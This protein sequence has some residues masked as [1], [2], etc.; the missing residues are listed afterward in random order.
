MGQ[1][2]T[3]TPVV[4][5]RERLRQVQGHLHT[6]INCVEKPMPKSA[7]FRHQRARKAR[8]TQSYPPDHPKI[9]EVDRDLAAIRIEEYVRKVLAS[10]PP[11][12]YQQHTKLAELLRPVRIRT[13]SG[14]DAA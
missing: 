6:G 13:R 8:L 4:Q 11:L 9:V 5:S 1:A 12:T 3:A 7:E 14:G 2:Q 10:A